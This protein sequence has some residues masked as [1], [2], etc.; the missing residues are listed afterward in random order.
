MTPA[1]L[2]RDVAATAAGAVALIAAIGM[3]AMR[4][5]FQR[6]HYVTPPATVSAILL[7]V[8]AWASEG[9]RSAA[10]KVSFAALVLVAVNGVGTTLTPGRLVTRRS[11]GRE[12][13][14]GTSRSSP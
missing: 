4:D 7:A 1:A 9:Q 12:V 13:G 10:A 2:V 5:P 14:A 6:L 11:A 8:A 3:C